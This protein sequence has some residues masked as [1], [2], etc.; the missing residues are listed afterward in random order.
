MG[1]GLNSG[2]GIIREE[3]VEGE[4]EEKDGEADAVYNCEL[5]LK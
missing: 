5:F 3:A 4:T 2:G 1:G